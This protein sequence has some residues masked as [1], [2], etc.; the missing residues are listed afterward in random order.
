MTRRIFALGGQLFLWGLV[1][2]VV[3][4]DN[5]APFVDRTYEIPGYAVPL[6]L[7]I[8]TYFF[9]FQIYCD[10]SGYTDMAR[11]ASRLFGIRLSENFRR[12]YFAQ[13]VGEFWS[14]RWHISLSRLVPRLSLLSVHGRFPPRLR[15]YLG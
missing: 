1:K 8:A 13:S 12:S 11:G 4:A 7:I 6:E 14:R 2:K 5:L 15:M 3:V 9:A 10:F